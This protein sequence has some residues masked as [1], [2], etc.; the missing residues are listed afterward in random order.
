VIHDHNQ[1]AALA[2]IP[3]VTCFVVALL[4][5]HAVGYTDMMLPSLPYHVHDRARTLR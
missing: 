5:G 2:G 3:R 1:K 4:W